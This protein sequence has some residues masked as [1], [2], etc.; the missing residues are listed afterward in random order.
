MSYAIPADFAVT[1][2]EPYLARRR[3]KAPTCSHCGG[4]AFYD[5]LD[6]CWSCLMCS[7]PVA[8]PEGTF[9][10]NRPRVTRTARWSDR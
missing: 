8:A 3:G 5:P 9:P 6:C 4:A 2:P 7:R 10:E 1:A